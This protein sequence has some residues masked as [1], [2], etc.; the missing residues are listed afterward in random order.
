MLDA[1]LKTGV[2][3]G[4]NTGVSMGV[5]TGVSMGVNMDTG[6]NMGRLIYTPERNGVRG[7]S[8]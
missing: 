5:N 7:G 2:S 6:V 1:G 4:V 3:T 8:Y